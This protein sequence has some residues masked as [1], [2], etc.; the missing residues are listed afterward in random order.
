M[1]IQ[2]TDEI[3]RDVETAIRSKLESASVVNAH[4]LA[5]EFLRARDNAPV[6]LE[7]LAL[8]IAKLAMK[9]GCAVEFGESRGARVDSCS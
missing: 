2:L 6:P 8:A 9:R 5:A 4:E 1:L 3:Q 7:H